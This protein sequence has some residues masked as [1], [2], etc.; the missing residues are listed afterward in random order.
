MYSKI[1]FA[2]GT[3]LSADVIPDCLLA[4]EQIFQLCLSLS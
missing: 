1:L 4:D 3:H 2:N